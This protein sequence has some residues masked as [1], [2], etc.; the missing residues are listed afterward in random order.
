MGCKSA[1][2]CKAQ[3]SG[4]LTCPSSR[5]ER[6]SMVSVSITEGTMGV[7]KLRQ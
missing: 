7:Y 2:T 3:T 5:V 4:S 6:C 1:A